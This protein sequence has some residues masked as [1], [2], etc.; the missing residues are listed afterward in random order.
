MDRNVILA[1][2]LSSVAVFG[3]VVVVVSDSSASE[4]IAYPTGDLGDGYTLSVGTV[5]EPSC[6]VVGSNRDVSVTIDGVLYDHVVGMIVSPD[7]TISLYD[8]V[9]LYADVDYKDDNIRVDSLVVENDQILLDVSYMA[10]NEEVSSSGQLTFPYS[11]VVLFLV[12]DDP[13][14]SS[15]VFDTELPSFASEVWV[16]CPFV[17]A[18]TPIIATDAYCLTGGIAVL[19]TVLRPYIPLPYDALGADLSAHFTYDVLDSDSSLYFVNAFTIE[20]KENSVLSSVV[21]YVPQSYFDEFVASIGDATSDSDD[22]SDPE[23]P[24][25]SPTI[26][27]EIFGISEIGGVPVVYIIGGLVVLVFILAIASGVRRR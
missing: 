9:V 19:G 17:K 20:I 2:L 21:P 5:V 8:M 11:D 15:P 16:R 25:G 1:F 7:F 3:G 18:D 13:I 14:S 27:F 12:N 22:P 6:S 10:Y 26:D 24:S 23:V 4:L